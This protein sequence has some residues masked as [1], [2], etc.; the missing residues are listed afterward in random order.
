M[1]NFIVLQTI[2]NPLLVLGLF[3][4]W[5]VWIILSPIVSNWW[6]VRKAFKAEKPH[7][8]RLAKLVADQRQFT[9]KELHHPF[10]YELISGYLKPE[11][12]TS[13]VIKLLNYDPNL[14]I[15]LFLFDEGQEVRPDYPTFDAEFQDIKPR[16]SQEQLDVYIVYNYAS[17]VMNDE[18]SEAKDM[19]PHALVAL[20]NMGLDDSCTNLES[21]NDKIKEYIKTNITQFTSD[22]SMK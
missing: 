18:A 15:P 21:L 12:I 5:L 20:K 13:E 4:A 8:L 9:E 11:Q 16:L 22:R 19:R 7:R 3:V 10:F 1:Q 6:G 17:H 2:A 14:I